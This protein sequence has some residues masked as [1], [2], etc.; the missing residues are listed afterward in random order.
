MK[1]FY[2]IKDRVWIHLGEQSLVEGRVVEIIDLEHLNEGHSKNH[3]L[4]V[5]EI[6][7]SIEPVYEVRTFDQISSDAEGPLNLYRELGLDVIS[8]NR[9]LKKIG[10]T[11]PEN[12]LKNA[13]NHPPKTKFRKKYYKKKR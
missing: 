2:D 8:G 11:V 6:P 5:I 9:A 13:H 1:K 3:E 4:Y 7:S 12:A 10:I